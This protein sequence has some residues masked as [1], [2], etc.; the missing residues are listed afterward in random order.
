MCKTR[1]IM[2]F[3]VVTGFI[4][5]PA[6]AQT[7][8]ANMPDMGQMDMHH[9]MQNMPASGTQAMQQGNMNGMKMNGNGRMNMGPGEQMTPGSMGGQM[10]MNGQGQ[11]QP[12]SK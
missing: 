9:G 1:L 7:G 2:T 11:V 4:A 8:M 10:Q 6:H 5:L 3:I 12:Q